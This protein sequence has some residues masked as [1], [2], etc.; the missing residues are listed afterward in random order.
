MLIALP[1]RYIAAPRG[2]RGLSIVEMMVGV[3]IGLIVV[4]AS[5]L[6][7]STQLGDNRRLLTETQLQQ[8]LR[9]SMDIITRELR[10]AGAQREE[11]VLKSL[12]QPN[13][14][15]VHNTRAWDLTPAAG[16]ASVVGFEYEPE[17]GAEVSRLGFERVGNVIKTNLASIGPQ[18]LTDGNVLKVTEFIVT[19]NNSGLTVPG[20]AP[21]QLPCPKKCPDG[22]AACWPRLTV[23]ELD[24]K[25]TGESVAFP[26]VKR[27]LQSNVRLRNDYLPFFNKVAE[28]V[29]PP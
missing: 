28:Q 15:A 6:L 23:R 3:A 27:S 25:I 1:P 22:T 19:A 26:E 2:Q 16:F 17:S 13:Q 18:E 7:V 14:T 9:A 21:E 8:D 5:S 24:V 20:S 11:G 10:R 4:A 12:W 29:C